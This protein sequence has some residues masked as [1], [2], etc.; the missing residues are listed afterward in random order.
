[1]KSKTLLLTILFLA[2]CAIGHTQSAPTS[3]TATLITTNSFQHAKIKEYH[4][5]ATICCYVYDTVENHYFSAFSY[6]NDTTM[7]SKIIFLSG[8]IVNDFTIANDSVFFCGYDIN[9]RGI[10]GFFSIHDLFYNDGNFYI[11]SNFIARD[12]DNYYYNV[13]R[14]TK[15]VTLTNNN[16]ERHIVCIGYTTASTVFRMACMVDFHTSSLP[17][18][19]ATRPISPWSY[20]SGLLIKRKPHYLLDIAI[21]GDYIITA[22]FNEY[23]K[24]SLRKHN[25]Q[26]VFA[27]SG[28]QNQTLT[29]DIF[30]P[31]YTG[32]KE[33]NNDELLLTAYTSDTFAI[34]ATWIDN[35]GL[36]PRRAINISEY[37]INPLNGTFSTSTLVFKTLNIFGFPNEVS[38]KGFCGNRWTRKLALLFEGRSTND[39]IRSIFLE[40]TRLLTLPRANLNKYTYY[41]ESLDAGL[42]G[43]DLFNNHSQYVMAGRHEDP[44]SIHTFRVETSGVNSL[45]QPLVNCAFTTLPN[46]SASYSTNTF[47]IMGGIGNVQAIPRFNIKYWNINID[48]E[49]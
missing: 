26:N 34:A 7:R 35:T 12:E 4:Y 22:G 44:P 47:T 14:F 33:W 37:R 38:L 24:I 49:E 40:T 10:I 9:Q 17:F 2:L 15:L 19:D 13:E 20:E 31:S 41:N 39:S 16:N 29:F 42:G 5:P 11:Q 30:A 25:A 3:V 32:P 8:Y 18:P 36:K 45:C 46:I 23:D 21:V 48:C 43:I 6:Q 27:L 28:P 1:M